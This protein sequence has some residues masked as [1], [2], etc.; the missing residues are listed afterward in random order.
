MHI[1][2]GL[3]GSE[4]E[5]VGEP[6]NGHGVRSLHMTCWLVHFFLGGS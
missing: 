6:S 2:P 5:F 1:S 4:K 3:L